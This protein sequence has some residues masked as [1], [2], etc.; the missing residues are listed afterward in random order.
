MELFAITAAATLVVAALSGVGQPPVDV[1]DTQGMSTNFIGQP[2]P[3]NCAVMRSAPT[4]SGMESF[5][6]SVN[7]L[8][9]VDDR[10]EIDERLY[11][12]IVDKREVY[13]AG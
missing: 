4:D 8:D 13:N 5:C 9:P 1:D 2:G 3:V 10:E 11:D 7:G 12:A 6:V